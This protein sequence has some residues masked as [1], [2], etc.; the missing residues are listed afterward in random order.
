MKRSHIIKKI[1]LSTLSVLFLGS[2]FTFRSI[3][4]DDNTP[5]SAWSGP[6]TSNE[7]NYFASVGQETGETLKNKLKSI[8]SVGTSES[9]DWSRYEAADEAEG[10]SNSVLLIY[11]R[12]VVL[13]T[14]H[15][16][17]STGWNREHSFAKSLFNEA[18]P[19]VNDNHHIFADDN[20]TNSV[21]G[22]NPFNELNKSTSTR[23]VDGYGNLT[24]NYTSGSYFMPNDLAK[25][26][27]ARATMYM[28]T[29]YGYSITLNFYSIALML[30][31]HIEHPVTNREI[32]RNNV[33]HNLQGNRNPFIDHQDYACRIWS[34]T[35]SETQSL[36]SGQSTNVPVTSVS[37]SPSS[38]TINLASTNKTLQLTANVLPATATN[39]LVSWSS[40]NDNVASVSNNGF[41]TALGVGQTTITATSLENNTIKGTATINV[42]NTPPATLNSLSLSGTLAKNTYTTAESWSTSGLNVTGHYSDS[43]SQNVTILVSWSFNPL[44]PQ[45]GVTSLTVTATYEG[46]S[47]SSSYGVSVTTTTNMTR[48]SNVSDLAYGSIY[49]IGAQASTGNFVMVTAIDPDFFVSGSVTYL[50]NNKELELNSNIMQLSLEIGYEANTFAFKLVN[51][52]NAGKFISY[53]GSS[54]KLYTSSTLDS[55]S[56]WKITIDSA[57]KATISNFALSARKI[58]YN[59][60]DPRFAA[61]TTSQVLPSLYV[62]GATVDPTTSA[63]RLVDAIN[64]GRGASAKDNCATILNVLNIAYNQLSPSARN[65]FDTSNDSA[66]ISARNRIAYL[67]AW[68]ASNSGTSGIQYIENKRDNTFSIV[69]ISAI[70]LI[71]LIGF[72]YVKRR[73]AMI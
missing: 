49:T 11:S 29:R 42:T 50:N 67:N 41:V 12:Q 69:L 59:S 73:K 39:P 1:I 60:M 3:L 10:Q 26:E 71:S 56:S 15:V 13:K 55:N 70:G 8:I 6:Q 5:V 62:N 54:N 17:G 30:R 31:W 68:V 46:K 63:T 20:K 7:G 58:Q 9:Y 61:Y 16:S 2:L 43:S 37:V 44:S 28:N 65:V 33:V 24:D 45:E 21:R 4:K 64:N 47:V 22:N 57:G 35:N 19:A 18:A 36:C 38:G 48:V 27:V 66:F 34:Q 51:S 32:Y 72:Y 40:S 14:A 52:A 25:G 53:S 23:V